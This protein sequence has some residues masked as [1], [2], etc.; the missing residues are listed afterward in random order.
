MEQNNEQYKK[1]NIDLHNG[2][3]YFVYFQVYTNIY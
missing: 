3:I 2:L 1:K